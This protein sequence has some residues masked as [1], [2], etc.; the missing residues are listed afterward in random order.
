MKALET[1]YNGRRFRSRLE[2]RWAVFYD[3]LG[4]PYA[5]EPEGF[6]L[7]E[8]GWYL[9]DFY[10]PTLDV[11]IEIKGAKPTDPE[12]DRAFAL[13]KHSNKDVYIFWGYIEIPN[14][15]RDW[16]YS[17]IPQGLALYSPNTDGWQGTNP[18]CW[19][20]QC[21]KCRSIGIRFWGY[22]DR[23]GCNCGIPH[24]TYVDTPDLR[25]AYDLATSARFER[26]ETPVPTNIYSLYPSGAA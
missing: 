4:I 2:A 7:D 19:W 10:L 15:D 14:P 13:A 16:D 12:I 8:A 23:L 1:L 11:W 21:P 20:C 22:A 18:W 26:G 25:R 17:E 3:A 24:D 6:D 5:Y 9:P